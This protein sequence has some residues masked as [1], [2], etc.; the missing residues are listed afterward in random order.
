MKR[1]KNDAIDAEAICEAAQ[2][3]SMRFVAVK[4]EQQQAAG[5]VFRTRDLLVRQRTQLIN[6]IRG[7]LTEYGRVAPK[8]PSHVAMLT[9]L[10]EE[11]DMASSLPKAA[12]AMFRLMLDLLT[13]LDGKVADLDQEI[14]RISLAGSKQRA[15]GLLPQGPE[16]RADFL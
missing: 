2:R 12:H 10:I 1:Q 15:S 9:D 6:A 5:P 4:S 16:R 3:P 14:A 8:G 7:H 11:E 13:D